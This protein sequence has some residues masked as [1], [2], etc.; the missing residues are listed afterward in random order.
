MKNSMKKNSLL[1]FFLA[2]VL[3]N[4][5]SAADI[6]IQTIQQTPT[7]LHLKITLPQPTWIQQGSEGYASYPQAVF[8]E[9]EQGNYLPVL[10]KFLNLAVANSKSIKIRALKTSTQKVEQYR[11][12]PQ[13]KTEK[14]QFKSTNWV[15]FEFLGLMGKFPIY[16]LRIYPV[17]V[18]KDHRQVQLLETI[19][20]EVGEKQASNGLTGDSQ[21]RTP[22]TPISRLLQSVVINKDKKLF[23]LSTSVL[24]KASH[25]Y[26]ERT[27]E[28]WQQILSHE[29]VLKLTVDQ[30]GIYQVTYDDLLKTGLSLTQIDPQYLHLYN[31]GKEIPIYFKGEHDHQ[32]NEEDYFEFWGQRHQRTF[33]KQFPELYSDP[34]SD[35]NVYWLVYEN[36]RGLRLVEESGGITTSANQLVISPFAFTDTL[37]VEE[38]KVNH[39]FG[40]SPSLLNRPAWQIDNFYFDGGISSPGGVGYDFEIP[41]PAEFGTNVIVRAMFR[42]KSFYDSQNNPLTGHQV[43]VKLR[44]KGNVAHLVGTVKPQD[45]WKDQ[46][47]WI[48]TNE[49]SVVKI[50]QTALNDGTN[51]LEVDMFQNG[52]TDIV[53][54]NWFEIIYLRKYQAYQ[55]YLKFHVDRDFFDGRYVKLG[56]RI[57]FNIDGFTNKNID[58]YKIGISKITNVDIK[59]VKNKEKNAFSYGITFQDEVVDPATKYVAVTEEQKKKVKKIEVFRSWKADD[60]Q[61]NLLSTTNKTDFLIITHDLFLDEVE[62]LKTLKQQQGF[63]PTVV[64]VRDIYDQFNYGIKSPLAI[65]EFIKYVYH[66]WDQSRPLEYVLLVGDAADNYRSENDLVPTLFYNTVKF[67]A[68]ESD[69]QYALLEGNDY[70][71]EI[72]VARL[73]VNSVYELQNY[74][75]KIAHYP[76]EPLGKWTNQTLFISGYDATDFEYLTDKPVFRAQSL[77]LIQHR[78]PGGLFADQINSVKDQH[79]NP[80]LH[81]GNN[82]DV[83]NAF[84]QGVAFIN[85]VGHGGG[86]IWADAGLMDL[87]DVDRLENGYKLPFISSLTC[88][89]ASFA[90]N[91]RYSLGEKLVLSKEK[92]AIGFLGSAGVG[93]KYND[94]AIAWSLPDFLWNKQFSFGEAINLMKMFY[95][96]SPFY[97]SEQGR[98]YSF[99]YGSISPSQ[100]SQY[101][102]LGD[103][104]LQ[105]PFPENSLKLQLEPEVAFPGDSV[106]VTIL[107]LPSAA[108]LFLQV[109]DEENYLILDEHYASASV[110]FKWRFKVPEDLTPQILRI[111]AF[112]TT[113]TQ[114]ANGFVKLAI[115]QPL[116][117]AV[118]TDPAEPKINQKIV[119]KVI[120]KTNTAIEKVII[121]NL[122]DET[123]FDTYNIN[124]TLAP[125]NDSTFVSQPFN[126]FA[127]GGNKIFDVQ[128]VTQDGK[129]IT[130]HWNKIYID[131]PRPDILVEAQSLAWGGQA[132]LMLTFKV[133]NSTPQTIENVRVA[134]FDTVISKT[135]PFALPTLSLASESEQ[136]VEVAMPENMGYHPYHQIKIIADYDSLLEERDENNNQVVTTLF[137]N[138]F[139]VSP[140]LGTSIDGQ[141]HQILPLLSNWFFEVKPKVTAKPF[142]FSFN[143]QNIKQLINLADQTDLKFVKNKGERDT[144][145]LRL[146]LPVTFSTQNIPAQLSIRLDSIKSEYAKDKISIY[147]FDPS[148][149]IWVALT[150]EWKGNQLQTTI[151]NSGIYA[152]F[153]TN[154]D[155]EPLV[156]I[157]VNGRPLVANM[158][159]P[160]KPTLGI[161]LQDVNGINFK[162]SLNLKIDDTF[163]IQ[164]GHLLSDQVTFPDSNANVKNVQIVFTPDLK[165]G[166]HVLLLNATDVNGNEA[167]TTL[168]FTVAAG[169]DLMVYGNY[170]N[171]FK[172]RTIISYYIES[173]EEIDDLNI[174]IYTTS[175]RLIRSKMLELDPTI[176]DDNL[177][178]PNYHELI[179]DGTDDD[180]NQVANGVYFAIIKAKYKG[181]V[182][183]KTLKMARLQ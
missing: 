13:I 128:V 110:P 167:E 88:F 27:L 174:K 36:R 176:L 48:V 65:K 53:V 162:N 75:D 157:S 100:V 156:E 173:N 90:N 51:R 79:K 55:D 92:G 69:Y 180:G 96:A 142:V 11:F 115:S 17:H 152:P 170:P 127:R 24:A 114:S 56:D 70:L 171:P 30:E 47:S 147:R 1:V 126:G 153:F 117:K 42:G 105:M 172:E 129:T 179:W 29:F 140:E 98:F 52:V 93:W 141:T 61:A 95:L 10:V 118:L 135:E 21:T 57:Q 175:G 151:T 148:L 120:L 149:N 159:V 112:A 38:N 22:N 106:A 109:T 54:L 134:C 102:L 181:K 18:S 168:P 73:P 138:Y 16:A 99:G 19:E 85:F 32:F 5:L 46:L 131:D 4:I 132:K 130:A 41:H 44:G 82:L 158:L 89:T 76:G 45:G 119:F 139:V 81:F 71:P 101:N 7:Y 80:D 146:E 164:N 145:G 37:H 133:K 103:P 143:A 39:K 62:N 35:E 104:S 160:H 78:I 108:E 49:D 121:K 86:A 91:G 165:P 66:F 6:N 12:N 31:K 137:Q 107:G 87:D 124:L 26:Y 3:Q 15:E 43:S 136:L 23:N 84:D 9:D 183:K 33:Q 122:Y 182:I 166:H 2:F 50:E 59:P 8:T 40:H 150:S 169:F 113:P 58:V 28:R 178:E 68:A 25:G 155:K 64:T 154:D 144:L 111:K 14:G 67:G 72:I 74:I 116:V 125:I 83:I 20:V 163:I 97:Y 177:L 34:F 77:R 60:P 161:L 94:F 63:L 123:S